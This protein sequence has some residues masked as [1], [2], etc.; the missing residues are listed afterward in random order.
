MK[1]NILI[2]GIIHASLLASFAQVC[3]PDNSFSFDGKVTTPIGNNGDYA[4]SAALQA[5]NKIVVAGY[6]NNSSEDFALIR[7]NSDGTLDNTFDSDGK[8]ITDFGSNGDDEG[9]SLA[10]QSDGKIIVAGISSNGFHWGFALIR[11]NVD[12]S[13]DNSFASN[14]KVIT[15]IG[16]IDAYAQ[17]VTLQSDGK[18]VVAGY[19]SDGSIYNFAVVRYNSNGSLDT[20]FGLEGKMTTNFGNNGALAYSSAIQS[21]GKI[22]VAGYTIIGA[23]YDFALVRYNTDGS[24]DN[25]FSDDGKITTAIGIATD[26]GYS[27]GIQSDGKIVV[28]GKSFN[29]SDDD[30]ALVR[31]NTDGT[32][33]NT[34][35]FDGKVTTAIGSSSDDGNSISI[36]DDGK[37]VVAG[38]SITNGTDKAFTLVRYNTDG[39]LDNTCDDDGKVITAIGNSDSRGYSVSIQSN[40]K[41]V[42]AGVNW[43]G[44]DY[45]VAVA[46]FNNTL[47]GINDM[48]SS[49]NEW[50]LEICPNPSNG[51]IQLISNQYSVM[52]VG[53]YNLLGDKI[54]SS[55]VSSPQ[56]TIN[57][58]SQPKGIYFV[59][60]VLENGSS[61]GN[62]SIE[63][64]SKKIILE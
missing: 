27:V 54:Y 49:N 21:D 44:S 14:G 35:D 39:S 64:K 33:D 25:T 5:D 55:T 56:G 4:Y 8:V 60:V 32:L 42:V 19:I 1:K 3:S 17:S 7:Y 29:G 36:Q 43:N 47:T 2:L 12:G 40:G 63:K 58:S 41:I 45:D 13:V 23:K 52:D 11:Y 46:R 16:S 26:R 38:S 9:K 57:L 48:V 31:Y 20:S 6:C 28:A 53:V 50:T 37:I 24:L 62:G 18:I 30:F 10:I 22:L 34:F 15:L 61:K 59:E 51:T